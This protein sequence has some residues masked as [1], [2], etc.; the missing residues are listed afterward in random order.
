MHAGKVSTPAPE[1]TI[2]ALP[3]GESQVDTVN[4]KPV[5]AVG[6]DKLSATE[7]LRRALAVFKDI[8][9]MEVHIGTLVTDPAF[10]SLSKSEAVDALTERTF[11]FPAIQEIVGQERGRL[12]NVIERAVSMPEKLVRQFPLNPVVVTHKN[13]DPEG[14]LH[15]GLVESELG[16]GGCGYVLRIV[17]EGR[18]LALK[19]FDP[20]RLTMRNIPKLRQRFV[21][22]FQ[23]LQQLGDIVPH[24]EFA[25]GLDDESQTPSFAME[26]VD[27]STIAQLQA[28]MNR[29]AEAGKMRPE[30]WMLLLYAGIA[31]SVSEV[32]MLH[33]ARDT[34]ADSVVFVAGNSTT[35]AM[36]E[37]KKG[38]VHRDLKPQNVQLTSS[39]QIKILDFGMVHI[40]DEER[41]HT[42]TATGDVL[43][44]PL[45]MA[46][47]LY[48]GGNN[49]K[50]ATAASDVYAMG[51]MLFESLTG[52]HPFEHVSKD[53]IK[54][55]RAHQQE[56]PNFDRI[57][58]GP[59]RDLLLSMFSKNPKTRP[60]MSHVAEVLH[61]EFL[62]GASTEE[63]QTYTN[64]LKIS[65][66]KRRIPLPPEMQ[67]SLEAAHAPTMA[68]DGDDSAPDDVS[69][70]RSPLEGISLSQQLV[71]TVPNSKNSFLVPSAGNVTYEVDSKTG[72]PRRVSPAQRV[73]RTIAHNRL[74]QSL[75][76]LS[77]LAGTIAVT[78]SQLADRS[79][80]RDPVAPLVASN[81]SKEMPKEEPLPRIPSL[82]RNLTPAEAAE[83]PPAF[84]VIRKEGKIEKVYAFGK[85]IDGSNLYQLA[86]AE[87]QPDQNMGIALGYMSDED[88]AEAIFGIPNK[89][90]KT[91]SPSQKLKDISGALGHQNKYGSAFQGRVTEGR[92]L[93][94]Y[95]ADDSYLIMVQG[96]CDV[97][98]ENASS[99]PAAFTTE[100]FAP[101]LSHL[102]SEAD[103]SGSYPDPGAMKYDVFSRAQALKRLPPSD[104]MRSLSNEP[105][106]V[107]VPVGENSG[108]DARLRKLARGVGKY[109]EDPTRVIQ[110]NNHNK[111][112]VST[113]AP[114]DFSTNN[115]RQ[116]PPQSP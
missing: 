106:F 73:A 101:H 83:N 85:V 104:Q 4:E 13:G 1:V 59:L 76:A 114:P 40:D 5:Q 81:N 103:F 102:Q 66:T 44:T 68:R 16:R 37:E 69:L 7:V 108:V 51:V 38:L 50:N 29:D 22:E 42:M 34:T 75:A 53:Q 10:G 52:T 11:E 80:E 20:N 30:R 72:K 113:L 112:S 89:E 64:F 49:I 87:D 21:H 100:E 78:K 77:I 14:A 46:P 88:L 56:F 26:F 105:D 48:D 57:R 15:F 82:L 45:Y 35:L 60:T 47:E 17:Y 2:D 23:V 116:S 92:E 96:I 107:H 55:L 74:A 39:G 12:R 84:G 90:L 3:G 36:Q 58:Q 61:K 91:I 32:H 43:G 28:M 62:Q 97:L 111:Q 8:P 41:D 54:L 27:G 115:T 70:V 86:P 110:Q 31:K 98:V 67:A 109:I 94:I 25:D 63:L 65:A 71:E 93:Q 95:H 9:G 99:R 79:A 19:V 24:P 6:H 33:G 18:T